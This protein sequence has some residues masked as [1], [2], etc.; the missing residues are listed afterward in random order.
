MTNEF[1]EEKTTLPEG[2]VVLHWPKKISAVSYEELEYWMQGLLRRA[3]RKAC[4]S[5]DQTKVD[6]TTEATNA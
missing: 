5:S 4:L 3:R 6:E 1:D 2:A